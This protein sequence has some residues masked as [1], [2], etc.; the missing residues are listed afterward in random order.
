ML[1]EQEKPKLQ[2][3]YKLFKTL[4][5]WIVL[6]DCLMRV[7]KGTDPENVSNRVAFIEK[8]PRVRI[9]TNK[10]SKEIPY[11]DN[12][13]GCESVEGNFWISGVKGDCYDPETLEDTQSLLWSDNMLTLLGYE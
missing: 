6:D 7:L 1:N 11:I 9:P 3:Q 12:Y 10:L 4:S 5:N 13:K 2:M 8:T